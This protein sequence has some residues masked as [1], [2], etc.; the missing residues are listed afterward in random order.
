[1]QRAEKTLPKKQ[2]F[3]PQQPMGS[4]MGKPV[5]SGLAQQAEGRG[6]M[7]QPKVVGASTSS[8][9]TAKGGLAEAGKPIKVVMRPPSSSSAAT[10]K[11]KAV[12]VTQVQKPTGPY[13]ES[14]ADKNSLS[15][16]VQSMTEESKQ[17]QATRFDQTNSQA[18]KKMQEL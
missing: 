8:W 12:K 10:E 13:E 6:G 2:P 1:M 17:E 18:W 14:K 5:G 9:Q 4:M 16:M 15:M 11:T 7:V 3:R